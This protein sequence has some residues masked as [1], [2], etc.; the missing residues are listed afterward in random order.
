MSEPLRDLRTK[1]TTATDVALEAH[2]R[3]TGADKSEI[4]REVLHR[5]ALQQLEISRVMHRLAH[6]EGISGASEGR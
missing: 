6:A 5:W 3:A 1:V 4:A 2:A